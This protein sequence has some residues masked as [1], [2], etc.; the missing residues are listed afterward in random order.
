[1][2][3]DQNTFPSDL[4]QVMDEN[5]VVKDEAA[6]KEVSD[7]QLLEFYTWM[8][9]MRMAD[10]RITNLQRTGKCGTY[11]SIYGQEACQVGAGLALSKQDWLVPTFRETG[12]MWCFGVPLENMLLYWMGNEKGS[13]HPEG[14]NC[15]PIVIPVGSHLPHATGI[16]WANK[17]RKIDDSVVFC[18]FSD[19]ATS[20]G[21]FHAA[22]NF[23]AV[24]ETANVFFC[25]NNQYAISTPRTIQTA[26]KTIAQKAFAYGAKAAFIDGNDAVAVYLTCKEAVR[27]AK[28]ENVP[29][30]IEAVT[31]RLGDH[32]TTDNSKLYREDVEVSNWM[33]KEPL[34]RVRKYL[35][36][37]QLWDDEK[38][39]ELFADA[40]KE[41]EKVV[42]ICLNTS[43]L[44]ADNI[45]EMLYKDIAPELREQRKFMECE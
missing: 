36:E 35:E 45:F 38:E 19:G 33:P 5:G 39:S 14:V 29:V 17:L 21:D 40:E 15:L 10:Q 43:L 18:S 13:Q 9:K 1:M 4:Y 30:L 28:E 25:Q 32:T 11:A 31:Y 24:M 16:A 34:I 3:Y 37:H 20:E 26:S 7:E 42:E 22:L 8:V 41:I 6:M 2:I 23:A 44:P 12:M 27:I